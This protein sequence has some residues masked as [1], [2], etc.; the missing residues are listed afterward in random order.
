M[1]QKPGRNIG[2]VREIEG[3]LNGG[4]T[5]PRAARMSGAVS[6]AFP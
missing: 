6:D 2:A 5:N 4:D 3:F 1:N